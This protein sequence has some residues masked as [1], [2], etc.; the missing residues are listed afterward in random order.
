MPG[1]LSLEKLAAAGGLSWE[2]RPD[3]A[4]LVPVKA[5]GEA[6]VRLAPALPPRQ[7]AALAQ[8]MGRRVLLAAWPQ[9]VAVV[10]DDPEVAAWARSMGARVIWEPGRGLNLAVTAS[11]A[12]LAAEGVTRVTVAHAD[13]PLARGLGEIGCEGDRAVEVMCR[14]RDWPH[15]RDLQ[16]V[17]LVPDRRLDGTN[18]ACVPTGSGFRF[19]YG[20]GSFL[21]HCVEALRLGLALEVLERPDLAWDVDLPDDLEDL[22][23]LIHGARFLSEVL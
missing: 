18:V 14:N 15:L 22:T 9:P 16:R 1:R 23:A 3:T 12:R 8:E 5:F 21:R 2:E 19:S 17:T 7:R 11:I 4:V 20:P 13:L 6:K 10:C